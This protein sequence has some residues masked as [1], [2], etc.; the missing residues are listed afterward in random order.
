MWLRHISCLCG[1]RPSEKRKLRFQTACVALHGG[2]A[3]VFFKFEQGFFFFC[4]P[5]DAY[6]AAV[7]EAAEEEFFGEGAAQF[8]LDEAV[9]GARAHL[10]VEALFG[11]V[12][13][14]FGG[15]FGFDFFGQELLFE[16]Q[17]EFVDNAGD[18]GGAEGGEGDDGVE[19]VAEFGGEG[20]VDGLHFVAA[21]AF[22]GE[23]ECGA[24]EAFGTGVG[25]HDDDG[26]AEVRAFA[27]VVG[28]AA[29]VHDLQ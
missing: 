18:D 25:G 9:H 13:A 16:L 17:Q 27:V 20:F 19:A 15:E 4:V 23:A 2:G 10:R 7:G 21:L 11:E 12:G 26:V 5:A 8:V 3:G 24:A 28:E 14:Q 6:E 1:K 22:G 29:G